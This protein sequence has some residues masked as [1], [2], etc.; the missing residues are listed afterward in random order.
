MNEYLEIGPC[1][2]EEDCVGVGA[3]NYEQKARK[4]CNAFIEAIRKKLGNEPQGAQ[5]RVKSSP[6][7]FGTYYEVICSYNEVFPDSVDYAY[8]CESDS[9]ATWKE[10][11]MVSPNDQKNEMSYEEWMKLVD[12]E[13]D[14]QFG[15]PIDIGVDWPSRDTYNAGTQPKDAV[16]VWAEY[17]DFDPDMM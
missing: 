2:P 7:D 14:T 13:L 3:E 8:K 5:L 12:K 10:V 6:H 4:E 11:G 15:I 17:N 16:Q 1:P 9:P